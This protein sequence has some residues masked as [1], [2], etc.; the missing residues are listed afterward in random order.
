MALS[1]F[2]RLNKRERDALFV[3]QWAP[4]FLMIGISNKLVRLEGSD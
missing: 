3:G 1:L 2:L 4:A